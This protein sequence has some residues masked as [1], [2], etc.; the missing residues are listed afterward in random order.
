MEL[1]D[2]NNA[3]DIFENL[4]EANSGYTAAYLALGQTYGKL[5]RIPEAH[6]FLGIYHYELGDD[7]TAQYHLSR[8]QQGLNDPK[9][10]EK[11]RRLLE[12]IGKLPAEQTQ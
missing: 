1:G 4:L 11:T 6:Y 7:R 9:K 12:A 3:V 5:A 10:I 2:F 8:A